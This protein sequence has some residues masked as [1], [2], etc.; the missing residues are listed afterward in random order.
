MT[1]GAPGDNTLTWGVERAEDMR[2]LGV[3]AP[4]L[5]AAV[6]AGC[7]GGELAGEQ[8]SLRAELAR[9]RGRVARLETEL[10]LQSRRV[11]A[12]SERVS[13]AVSAEGL[14]VGRAVALARAR[15]EKPEAGKAETS[16]KAAGRP[17]AEKT[18]S[19]PFDPFTLK[20][21]KA[22]KRAG[23]VPGPLDGKKG[24][25]TT[26]AIKAFQKENTLPE[27]GMA[28]EATWARLKGW[29]EEPK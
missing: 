6:L 22:L 2:R 23:H 13:L 26:E 7:A 27:T 3:G 5:A 16:E 17:Q 11:R 24:R 1:A 4:L 25:L 29:L 19:I 12:V 15:E 21:Q 8:E 14:A 20:V 28:D 9:L 10:E 18:G